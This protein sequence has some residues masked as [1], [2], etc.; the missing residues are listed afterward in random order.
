MIERFLDIEI[1]IQL[2]LHTQNGQIIKEHTITQ[3]HNHRH[4]SYWS[5]CYSGGLKS[6]EKKSQLNRRK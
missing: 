4:T 6:S 1:M 2:A 3:L 5:F